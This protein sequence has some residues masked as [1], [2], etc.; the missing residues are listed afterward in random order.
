MAYN[1]DVH[2]L[3]PDLPVPAD[4]GR[5]SH[6]PGSRLPSLALLATTG[7]RIDLS[8]VPG[9]AVVFAYPRSG[10]PNA[11]PLV[12][13]WDLIP[14]ARGCTPQTCSFRDLASDFAQLNCQVFGLSTQDAPYQRELAERLHLP[15][16]V[17]SDA[18][19]ALTHTLRLPTLTVAGQ[20]LMARLAWIQRDGVI[21]DVAYPVFPPDRNAAEMLE[22]VR[23]RTAVISRRPAT[24]DDRAFARRTHH[25]AYRDVVERQFGKWNEEQ[26]DQFF[27]ADWNPSTHEIIL[28]EDRPVGYCVIEHRADDVHVRE[29]VLD[30]SAQG[31]GIGSSII[32]ELQQAAA[33][34]RKPI[35]LGT[36]TEN[37]A[38][39]FYARFGF[40]PIGRTDTHVLLEWTPRVSSP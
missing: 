2:T 9:R 8:R 15:F 21:E 37:R 35:R 18:D 11:P 29:L 27:A 1:R 25:A 4:D 39:S 20:V 17:L 16:P 31:R 6:L 26:Q 14:G 10:Q 34:D 36:F 7:E 33:R 24:A 30:V 40:E 12:P 38:L 3:P 5:A 19:L 13:D 32:R 22:R 23:A 28:A